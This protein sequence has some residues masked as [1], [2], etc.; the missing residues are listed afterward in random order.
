MDYYEK[1]AIDASKLDD[2]KARKEFVEQ[3][4]GGDNEIE[5][6]IIYYL[7]SIIIKGRM[8]KRKGAQ[9]SYSE[10]LKDPRWQKKRLKILERDNWTCQICIDK[11][12]TLHIHHLIYLKDCAP[13][14]YNNNFLITVCAE[15]HDDICNEKPSI[16][17]IIAHHVL[18]YGADDSLDW[19]LKNIGLFFNALLAGGVHGIKEAYNETIIHNNG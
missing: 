1:V 14:E 17:D 4:A 15:C 13:W 19:F 2:P 8:Q 12:E 16:K 3:L 18:L 10:K 7:N 5:E 9:K 6:K 11:T